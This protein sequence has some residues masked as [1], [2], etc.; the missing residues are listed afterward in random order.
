MILHARDKK[1]G[2]EPK[3]SCSDV[4]PAKYRT[5]SANTLKYKGRYLFENIPAYRHHTR[6]DILVSGRGHTVP[7]REAG[8]GLWA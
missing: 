3:G 5:G 6:L 4:L 2:P 1:I 7:L 8:K